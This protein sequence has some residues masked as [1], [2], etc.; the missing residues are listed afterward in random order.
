MFGFWAANKFEEQRTSQQSHEVKPERTPHPGN[1][2]GSSQ[3]RQRKATIL[4]L[5]FWDARA[6]IACKPAAWYILTQPKCLTTLQL[7][8]LSNR[9]ARMR[10]IRSTIAEWAW[11]QEQNCFGFR[12]RILA[13]AWSEIEHFIFFTSLRKTRQLMSPDCRSFP[14]I[15]LI[16]RGVRNA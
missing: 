15:I 16:R 5:L 3:R 4:A 7:L 8:T 1:G 11:F 14:G 6:E 2:L 10:S 13:S 12:C 9:R